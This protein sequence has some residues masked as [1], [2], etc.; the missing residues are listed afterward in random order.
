[1]REGDGN[2]VNRREAAGTIRIGYVENIFFDR[3]ERMSLTGI[4]IFAIKFKV[5]LSKSLLYKSII[6]K[7]NVL[8]TKIKFDYY[9]INVSVII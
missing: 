3:K 7:V 6:H 9:L 2:R 8:F 1:M 4:H 5:A